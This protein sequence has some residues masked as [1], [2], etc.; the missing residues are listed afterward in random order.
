MK[1]LAIDS[2][3]ILNRAFYGIKLLSTPDGI[4]TNALVGFLNIL[5]KLMA[6]V[7]PDCVA[8]AF[9]LKGPTFRH[10]MYDGYKAQRKGMPAEL[11]QQ[12]PRIKEI[13][14]LMGYPILEVQGYEGDDILGTLAANCGEGDQCVIATGDRDSLQLV[15]E[16]VT[17]LL[18]TTKAGGAMYTAM[19]PEAIQEQYGIA[20]HQLI[21][22]KALM[23]DSSDNIPGVAGVGEKTALSLIQNNGTLD[24]IY[25][26]IE[27]IGL[28][29]GVRN[30]LQNGKD[31]AYMSRDLATIRCDVP[32]PMTMEELAPRPMQEGELYDLL[33]SLH[34]MK[35]IE[36]LGLKPSDSAKQQT[37]QAEA[38]VFTLGVDRPLP[39][40]GK[41]TLAVAAEYGQQGIDVL[42][43]AADGTVAL[44]NNP[45][46]ELVQAVCAL[47]NA[48]I[49]EDCKAL[50]RAV[51][52]CNLSNVSFDTRL[53]GYLL[54]PDANDYS[55]L[56]LAEECS[57]PTPVLE[58]ETP[59]EAAL[60]AAQLA[61]LAEH[62]KK[63]LE[64]NDQLKLLG[65]IEIPLAKVLADMERLGFAIDRESLTAFGKEL[66][67]EIERLQTAIYLSA[68]GEFNINSPKQ[69]GEVLF[70]RLGLPTR[71]K[72]KSGYSTNAEV[73]ES[74]SSYHP[75]VENVLEYRK[76]TKLRSTYVEGLGK[77]IGEDGR[78]HSVFN[79]TETRTGRISSAE[80]NLQNIPVRTELGAKMRG[81]FH[82]KPGWVLV[83]ADY[84]QI[85]LRVLAAIA[86]DTKM[87]EAFATGQDIHTNTAAQV[88][89]MPVEFVTPL[90]RT[91]AK[92][93]NF[94]IVYG[95]G[96]FSLSKDINVSVA[97]ADRYIKNYLKTYEGVAQYME[98][99]VADAN[100]CGYITTLFGRRRYLPELKSSN[101]NLR[102]FGERVAMNAPIQG[103][104][105]DIIKIAMIR[106]YDR[107]KKEGLQ[108]QLILQVHDELI[109][110]APEAEAARVTEILKQEMEGAVQLAVKLEVDAGSGKT[111][112][113]AH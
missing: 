93:V 66:D 37:L 106:V 72:T 14:T 105:A 6:D 112:G 32:L 113:E 91:Q 64:E 102:A 11:A 75:I 28:T 53:A 83:D 94:G 20:P 41:A 82:A 49:T 96:A 81:F 15:R 101:H 55:V 98:K 33:V 69:L 79:Q 65:E 50:Y 45:A 97:E 19:T 67:V 5:H 12:L 4:Y 46:P 103:T 71:K 109:V 92:A 21:D 24:A 56:R 76:Y 10:K 17:V 36:K 2:N 51:L 90:M 59:P 22:V 29:P 8:F 40:W 26:N 108:A 31:S 80:P 63:R 35:H 38:P 7:K 58:G 99:T 9:D 1:L 34:M 100:R 54:A 87:L 27:N 77:A 43:V 85:E 52:P 70:E 42:A 57:L 88:F 44:W 68:G 62:Q 104:A 48:K 86:N 111:W 78:I 60:R 107:L 25:E 3:S 110:E 23:G 89:G 39:D 84:S 95:I 18:A 74:L 73:L 47:P 16:N 61:A 30:K 13:L